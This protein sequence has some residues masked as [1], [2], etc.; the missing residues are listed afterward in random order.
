MLTKIAEAHNS[1]LKS[2]NKIEITME[3]ASRA[4]HLAFNAQY[5]LE[6]LNRQTDGIGCFG[7]QE[8]IVSF[9]S[10]SVSW[11]VCLAVKR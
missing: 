2:P 7:T 8:I 10:V 5:I 1:F 11:S 3:M 4:L 6:N 9:K